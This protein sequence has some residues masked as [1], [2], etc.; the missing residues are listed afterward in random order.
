MVPL[1]GPQVEDTN[2]WLMDDTFVVSYNG[3]RIIWEEHSEMLGLS[4][5]MFNPLASDTP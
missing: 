2:P 3:T 5:D 1:D 4:T